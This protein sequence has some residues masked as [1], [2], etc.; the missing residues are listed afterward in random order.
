MMGGSV[1]QRQHDGPPEE[2]RVLV[3]L[4]GPMPFSDQ[5]SGFQNDHSATVLLRTPSLEVWT[6]V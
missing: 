5:I 3:P 4:L 2:T 6:H 1:P